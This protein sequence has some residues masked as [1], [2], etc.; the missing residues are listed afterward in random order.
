MHIVC[1]K[2]ILA[3]DRS[4]VDQCNGV[5]DVI[6]DESFQGNVCKGSDKT[7]II[8]GVVAGVGSA[9]IICAV[10]ILVVCIRIRKTRKNVSLQKHHYKSPH[11]EMGSVKQFPSYINHAFVAENVKMGVID[12]DVYAT[13]L[14]E[15]RP[16]TQTLMQLLSQIRPKLR[17]M[18]SG[19]PR[20]PTYKGVIHQLCRVLV[21][22]HRQDNGSSIPSDA[23]G[24]IEWAQQMLED[25][26]QQ[27][28]L[29]PDP[30]GPDV[31]GD[32]GQGRIS[33]IDVDGGMDMLPSPVVYAQ[34]LGTSNES[35]HSEGSVNPYSSVPVP[36]FQ[37]SEPNKSQKT[38]ATIHRSPSVPSAINNGK[39]IYARS[40]LQKG[41]E[42][43]KAK[44]RTTGY[45]ANGRYYDPNP[46]P[47][48]EI[49]A[50]ASSYSDRS[51][52]LLTTFVPDR[53]RSRSLSTSEASSEGE[54][55]DGEGSDEDYDVFPFD[56][57][58]ATDPVE[59]RACV[60]IP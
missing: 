46:T 20:I 9:L 15:L 14:E 30:V 19:D 33:Y 56:P 51:T 28:E 2:F 37:D 42:V 53:P 6:I 17:A 18:D 8:I 21:L 10:I 47:Q 52:V 1:V 7:N 5:A 26:R 54:P 35:L 49:Y 40:T 48:P 32:L 24:L 41:N 13:Q 29:Q 4:C 59:N 23:L 55:V 11:M 45:F 12:P 34:P 58:E 60:K 57:K 43:T 36:L 22:L 44:N 31:L 50:P 25:H 38:Y 27:Q 39:S 16:H 3:D